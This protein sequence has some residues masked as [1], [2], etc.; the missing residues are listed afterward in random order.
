[1]AN[2]A[3]YLMDWAMSDEMDWPGQGA[4]ERRA[5]QA[6]STLLAAEDRLEGLERCRG[7]NDSTWFLDYG[8]EICCHGV[9]LAVCM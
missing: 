3:P 8:H 5:N 6:N 9:C 1:M 7:D 2:K 4:R